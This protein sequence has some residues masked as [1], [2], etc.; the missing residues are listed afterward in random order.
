[1]LLSFYSYDPSGRFLTSVTS[2]NVILEYSYNEYGDLI[3][4]SEYGSRK[5]ISY[6]DNGWI[7]KIED[8]DSNSEL[9]SCTEYRTSYNGRLDI[10]VSPANTTRSLVHDKMGNVISVVTDDSF[11]V[12]SI[13]LPYGRQSL[14]GDEVRMNSYTY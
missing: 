13:E 5:N 3:S 2:G 1:M 10:T 9:V 6:N 11:P 8:F 4:A 14:L 12:M 7:D